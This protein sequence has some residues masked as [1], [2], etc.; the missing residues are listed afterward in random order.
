MKHV[1]HLLIVVGLVLSV[2]SHPPNAR[3]CVCYANDGP[4]DTVVP[5]DKVVCGAD[6]EPE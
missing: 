1:L 5:A 4:K 6:R 2:R 3:H